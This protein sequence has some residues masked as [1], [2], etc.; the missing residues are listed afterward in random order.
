[1]AASPSAAAS[2]MTPVQKQLST[3]VVKQGLGLGGLSR[4]LQTLALALAWAGLGDEV[5]TEPEVNAA[6]KAQLSGAAAFMAT[7]HVELRRTLIDAGWLQ[8]D[9]FGRE[10][11]RVACDQLREDLRDIAVE[12]SAMDL[13]QWVAQRH[14]DVALQRE[15]GRQAWLAAQK[16]VQ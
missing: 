2:A 7:D 16:A 5:M 10:Y 8:R 6:L 14:A 3:L 13:P 4:S 15:Q 12:V 1:M 11:R 9:G